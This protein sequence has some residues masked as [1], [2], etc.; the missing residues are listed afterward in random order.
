MVTFEIGRGLTRH[1]QFM[2]FESRLSGFLVCNEF[3]GNFDLHRLVTVWSLGL[4][5]VLVLGI[6][7]LHLKHTRLTPQS[8]LTCNT[9]N[10]HIQL[11]S[12]AYTTC[13]QGTHDLQTIASQKLTI[14][15]IQFIPNSY[16]TCYLGMRDLYRKN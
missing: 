10:S 4:A 1:M 16:L 15:H 2:I 3:C 9:K 5:H 8:R 14:R 7:D 13:T 11:A 6:F 12:I